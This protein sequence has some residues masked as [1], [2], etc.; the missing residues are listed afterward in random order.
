MPDDRMWERG[1]FLSI[2]LSTWC[3]GRGWSLSALWARFDRLLYTERGRPEY[4]VHH[5]RCKMRVQ[6]QVP[7]RTPPCPNMEGEQGEV[8]LKGLVDSECQSVGD[9]L[10]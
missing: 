10:P 4:Q 1:R 7:D 2:V 6:G 5:T 9:R 3:E 8:D